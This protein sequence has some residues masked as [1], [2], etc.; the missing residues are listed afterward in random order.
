MTRTDEIEVSLA[1]LKALA[2]AKNAE[3]IA[4]AD[5]TLKL[6]SEADSLLT[7]WE[8]LSLIHAANQ[9]RNS[10]NIIV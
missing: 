7:L 8:N 6:K 3:A 10:V 4:A 5:H 9:L 1:K 2:S